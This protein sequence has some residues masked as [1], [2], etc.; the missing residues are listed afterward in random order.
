MPFGKKPVPGRPGEH[1]DFDKVYRV[2]MEHAIREAGMLPK[3]ADHETSSKIIHTDMFRDLRDSEVVLADLS[4]GNQNVFYELGIRHVMSN[5]GTVLMC[6]DRTD[7]PFDVKLSRVIFYAY[8]G[9][10]LDFEEV[11]RLRQQLKAALEHARG[12]D[13]D[14][15]VHALLHTVMPEPRIARSRSAPRSGGP[16]PLDEFQQIVA[17]SWSKTARSGPAVIALARKYGDSRF[18]VRS[19]AYRCMD[20]SVPA[21]PPDAKLFVARAAAYLE[22]YPLAARLFGGLNPARLNTRDRLMYAAVLSET[23]NDEK[24]ARTA[25][26]HVREVVESIR[27]RQK[28]AREDESIRAE[29]AHALI[30][31]GGLLHWKWDLL[32]GLDADFDASIEA[33]DEGLRCAAQAREAGAFHQPGKMAY[34][35]MRLLLMLRRREGD[36]DREDHELHREAV[37]E[38]NGGLDGDEPRAVSYLRWYQTIV[39]A[40]LGDGE[41]S[42]ARALQA[43]KDDA[44]LYRSAEDRGAGSRE[45]SSLRRFLEQNGEWLR[46]RTLV[47]RVSQLLQPSSASRELVG[48]SH[49]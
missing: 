47:G 42:E 46:N 38:L 44:V 34:A 18:G 9:V 15:P 8:D 28:K 24:G 12:S 49:R 45:Y 1:Y 36:R 16:D 41:E 14:S 39:L 23:T 21:L 6:N 20:D 35:H 22:E 11:E 48:F 31:L 30:T 5:R 27:S 3:R 37:L 40:D 29:L 43:L 19:L 33:F 32:G 4:L 25:L 2:V 13:P 17:Q 7:L 26:E 10:S